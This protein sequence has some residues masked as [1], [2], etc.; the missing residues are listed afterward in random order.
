VRDC[1]TS[2]ERTFTFEGWRYGITLNIHLCLVNRN[3][4][5]I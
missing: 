3:A 4:G 2:Q 1:S 5:S